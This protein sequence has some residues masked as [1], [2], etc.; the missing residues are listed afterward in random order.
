[1]SRFSKLFEYWFLHLRR[2]FHLLIG[3]AFMV[4]TMM[5]ATQ[6][7][8]AYYKIPEEGLTYFSLFGGFT[9]LLAILCL[10]SFVK[11]RNVR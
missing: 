7:Y 3:L 4:L 1:L 8:S 2:V 9:I 10:Y 11:A 5:A 6:T